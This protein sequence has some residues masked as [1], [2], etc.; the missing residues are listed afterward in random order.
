MAGEPNASPS[1]RFDEA[2]RVERE[3]IRRHELAATRLE[4]TA[5]QFRDYAVADEHARRRNL[6]RAATAHGRAEQARARANRARQRLL[7][8]GVGADPHGSSEAP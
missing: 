2:V 1:S 3:A 6:R 7:D 5:T 4:A 8:E